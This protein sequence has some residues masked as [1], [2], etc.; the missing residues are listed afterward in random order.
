MDFKRALSEYETQTI[1]KFILRNQSKQFTAPGIFILK[2]YYNFLKPIFLQLSNLSY[3]LI[4]NPCAIHSKY[5]S[6]DLLTLLFELL[7]IK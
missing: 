4:T 1:T 5:R 7:L 3:F 2:T 6:D